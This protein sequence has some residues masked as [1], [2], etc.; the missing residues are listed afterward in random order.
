MLAHPF[1]FPAFA[2]NAGAPFY[3]PDCIVLEGCAS[4]SWKPVKRQ[5][6]RH[7]DEALEDRVHLYE[8]TLKNL[9][10]DPVQ[11]QDASA[12]L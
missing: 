12:R 10:S 7:A 6:H 4:R 5:L 11:I 9:L 3:F 2:I 1:P 8:A